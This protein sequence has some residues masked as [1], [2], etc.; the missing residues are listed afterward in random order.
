MEKSRFENDSEARSWLLN[1][2]EVDAPE[3]K[4]VE[5]LNRGEQE[6]EE[7]AARYFHYEELSR[8]ANE[9]LRDR[10]DDKNSIWLRNNYYLPVGVF[11]W[12]MQTYCFDMYPGRYQT[13][14]DNYTRIKTMTCLRRN[15]HWIF[16]RLSNL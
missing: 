3:Y 10:V 2:L 12:L 13:R 9:R 1:C 6:P 11:Y 4:L 5:W 16:R 14:T 15:L 8:L 7:I